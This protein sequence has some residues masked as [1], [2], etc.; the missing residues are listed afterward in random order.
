MRQPNLLLG[1]HLVVDVGLFQ[2]KSKVTW[3]NQ[4]DTYRC[5]THFGLKSSNC[6]LFYP[7][8][9][10]SLLFCVKQHLAWLLPSAVLDQLNSPSE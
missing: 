8:P 1:C 5:R 3:V 10:I 6:V 4:L 9:L 7:F 2:L